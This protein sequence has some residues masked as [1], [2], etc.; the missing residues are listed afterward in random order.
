[1]FFFP[2]FPASWKT[3]QSRVP[4]YFLSLFPS[5]F[6]SKKVN[7][8]QARSGNLKGGSRNSFVCIRVE[9][10][11]Y[12]GMLFQLPNEYASII[13]SVRCCLISLFIQLFPKFW[14]LQSTVVAPQ[15]LNYM[16]PKKLTRSTN[17]IYAIWYSMHWNHSE[18]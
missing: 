6:T 17:L 14:K 8:S 10:I 9:R 12:H 7:S 4:S 2:F 3:V 18:R 1:M 15:S 11:E 16:S 13:L 5:P